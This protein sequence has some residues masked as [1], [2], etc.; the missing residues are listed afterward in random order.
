MI[1]DK[2]GKPISASKNEVK[3]DKRTNFKFSSKVKSLVDSLIELPVQSSWL[4]QYEIDKINRDSTVIAAKARRKSATLKKEILITCDDD[5]IKENLEETFNYDVINSILDIPFQ[6]FGVFELVWKEKD[7]IYYPELIERYYREFLLK[8][9]VLK[10]APYGI[11]QDIPIYKAVH[12]VYEAK[13]D[14]PYGQPLYNPLFWLIEF[15]NASMEFWVEL[16][17][18]FGTPWVIAKTE[19]NKDELADEIYNMLGG[20]GA[21]IDIDDEID[22]KTAEKSGN[23]KE[24]IEYIDDQ[25]RELLTGGNLTGNVKGGSHA[26]ANVHNEI[27][28]DLARADENIVNKVIR[29]VVKLFKEG[30]YL[31]DDI[32]AKLKDKDDPNKELVDRDKVIADMGYRPKKEYI[33]KTYNIEVEDAAP[34]QEQAMIQNHKMSFSKA[35]PQDE[36]DYQTQ[37]IDTSNPLTFQKQILEIVENSRSYDEV[38]KKL[39]SLSK[40][41][42]TNDLYDN[43]VKYMTNSSIQGVAEIEDENPNG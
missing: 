18:R 39:L 2:N 8:D 35:L 11:P 16:L 12:G 38:Q 32:Q 13:P 41:I 34:P 3:N 22:L 19:G 15:K 28:E 10:Y 20:D 21:T 25:I 30:N 17:E 26:A 1:V 36:L 5:I 29:Q 27:R 14:K 23:F 31:N 42:N 4:N 7:G 6:G 40:N 37:N 24:L 43:L 33:E 9:R